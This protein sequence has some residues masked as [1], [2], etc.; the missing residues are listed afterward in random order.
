MR[1]KLGIC[2]GISQ[3]SDYILIACCQVV[4]DFYLLLFSL[5]QEKISLKNSSGYTWYKVCNVPQDRGV[6]GR[7]YSEAKALVE[8]GLFLSTKFHF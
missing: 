4:G 7:V 1:F 6:G 8:G 5:Y 2:I 3:K